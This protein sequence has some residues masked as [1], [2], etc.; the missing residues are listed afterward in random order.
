MLNTNVKKLDDYSRRVVVRGC[1]TGSWITTY[2]SLLNGTLLSPE[3]YRD[4]HHLRYGMEIEDLPKN[5]DG[6]YKKSTVGHAL[7][8]K[9]GGLIIA[10]HNE[11]RDELG[12]LLRSASP[13]IWVE[14]KINTTPS[15]VQSKEVNVS[16]YSVVD[17]VDCC[18]E[19]GTDVS[20]V[21]SVVHDVDVLNEDCGDLLCRNFWDNGEDCIIDVRVT[22]LDSPTYVKT[23]PEKVLENQEK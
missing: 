6:C 9:V 19:G 22:D 10:R 7:S 23:S 13:G 11:I 17:E 12:H 15:S 21:G 18:L 20:K 2:P 8:C 3:E 4:N 16:N 5:C 14:P 1:N